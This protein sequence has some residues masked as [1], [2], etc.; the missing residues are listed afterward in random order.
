MTMVLPSVIPGKDKR[1][2][3]L[4]SARPALDKTTSVDSG[5]PGNAEEDDFTM[6]LPKLS[7]SLREGSP[8]NYRSPMKSMFEEA[9]ERLDRPASSHSR[10]Q[11]DPFM[12]ISR[13]SPV[14]R[15]ASPVKSASPQPA[16]VQIYEDPVLSDRAETPVNGERQVL[17]ELPVNENVRVQ[18]PTQS[19]D[20]HTSPA[21]SPLRQIDSRSS[22]TEQD[23][24]EALRNRR[25]LTSAVE[26]I[27]T[28]ALDA[29]GFRRV[30]DLAKCQL[31]IWD[32]G[33]KYDEL[34]SV[35]LDY[36]RSF[37]SD[38]RLNQLPPSKSAG[39]KTQ[40][41]SVARTLLTLQRKYA[42]T[43]HANAITT[44]LAVRQTA[45]S[46]VVSDIERTID[47]IVKV[48]NPIACIETINENLTSSDSA[49]E[50]SAARATALS[51]HTL[52]ALLTSA[53]SSKTDISLDTANA[54]AHTSARY[55]EHADAEVRKADVELACEVFTRFGD[56]KAAFW[57]EF[58]GVEE[59]RL[60]LLTYYI[61]R[62]ERAA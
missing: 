20:S 55:L 25:L 38:A 22:V 6:V 7:H 46:N 43:W 49:D 37:P 11:S 17:S 26:R 2:S 21:G 15:R 23:R 19:V 1:M 31:D 13:K 29:H 32:N 47:E 45:E 9:R 24:S 48:A 30:Q 33:T 52:R 53:R 4:M 51:L 16:E 3:D 18:S 58:K 34:M 59:G 60:G 36:L 14:A 50:G 62:R 39:L 12:E 40:A 8:L 27:R 28:R 42:G 41:L 57:T 10:K 56:D 35:L 54:L 44:V 5:M 61:A